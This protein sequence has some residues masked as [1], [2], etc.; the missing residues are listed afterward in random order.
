MINK[1]V[2]KNVLNV[3]VNPYQGADEDGY[4]LNAVA[5][6]GIKRIPCGRY[7]YTAQIAYSTI[8]K[9]PC[10]STKE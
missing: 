7:G 10:V 2:A 3:G 8:P 6:V 9:S 5:Q 4:I 1:Q